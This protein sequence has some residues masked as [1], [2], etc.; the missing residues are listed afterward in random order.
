MQA[1]KPRGRQR[2]KLLRQKTAAR[3]TSFPIRII[4]RPG[5]E[6]AFEHAREIARAFGRFPVGNPARQ[7]KWAAGVNQLLT[8]AVL[9][10][11]KA[12]LRA[13]KSGK[14]D[15]EFKDQVAVLRRLCIEASREPAL[16]GNS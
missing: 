16:R 10:I 2:G 8:D 6:S 3:R 14:E 5:L 4:P 9:L 11:K 12:E 7:K 15:E 1:K 13:Q